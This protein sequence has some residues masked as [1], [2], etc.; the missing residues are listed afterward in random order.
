[1]CAQLIAKSNTIKKSHSAVTGLA[2]AM[3]NINFGS[4]NFID[5]SRKCN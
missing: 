5:P 2:D 3:K 4:Q 1:M